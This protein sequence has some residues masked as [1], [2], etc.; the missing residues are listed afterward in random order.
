LGAGWPW[1]GR[2]RDGQVE[3]AEQPEAYVREAG[4]G[5][6]ASAAGRL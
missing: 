5:G 3:V 4:S 6:E 1:S 2:A